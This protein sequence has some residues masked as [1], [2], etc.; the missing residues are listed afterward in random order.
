MDVKQQR[1]LQA[2]P[3]VQA[4]C[5]ANPELVPA[6]VPPSTAW[7]PLTRRL[8]ALNTIVAQATTAAAEQEVQTKRATLDASDERSLRKHLRAEM[9]VV[10]QVAQALRQSVPGIGMLKMPPPTIRTEGLLESADALAKQAPNLVPRHA[11]RADGRV[12]HASRRAVL[13]A[14]SAYSIAVER[15]ARRSSPSPMYVGSH[16]AY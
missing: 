8:D 14:L 15:R 4:W 7:S 3:R 11:E 6:P 16:V 1:M 12:A 13:I 9:H 2:L 10:T 5:A